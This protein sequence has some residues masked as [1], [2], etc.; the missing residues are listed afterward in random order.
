MPE[1]SSSPLVDEIVVELNTSPGGQSW[2]ASIRPLD[3]VVEGATP[4]E[5]EAAAL[6]ALIEHDGRVAD[7]LRVRVRYGTRTE[8]AAAGWSF[9]SERGG[10]K[11]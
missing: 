9:V 1:E 6:L 2:R 3:I 8:R 11:R 5:A 4:A 10:P 7:D